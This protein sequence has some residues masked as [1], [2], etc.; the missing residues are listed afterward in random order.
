MIVV[1]VRDLMLT[2]QQYEVDETVSFSHLVD[3]HAERTGCE[4]NKLTFKV[5][6]PFGEDTQFSDGGTILDYDLTVE[7][8]CSA[9]IDL[10]VHEE[11]TL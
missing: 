5:P 11:L 1:T 2:E 7:E 6:H 9:R 4:V 3:I 10:T 8:V